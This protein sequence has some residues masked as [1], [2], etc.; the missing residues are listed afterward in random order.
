MKHI[1]KLFFLIC[2]SICLL[3]A[4]DGAID[5]AKKNLKISVLIPCHVNHVCYLYDLL[6]AYEGQTV[7]PDEAIIS[8]SEVNKTSIDTIIKIVNE[9]WKFPV[10]FFFSELCQSAGLNRNIASS[11]AVGDVFFYQDADDLPHSRSI[12]IIKYFFEHFEV[13]H[14]MYLYILPQQGIDIN[15]PHIPPLDEIEMVQSSSYDQAQSMG[16]ANGCVAVSRKVFDKVMWP[17]IH[18]A[19]DLTFNQK[20]YEHFTSCFVINVPVFIYRNYLST[21]D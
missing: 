11:Q 9:N 13:D 7:L 18:Y 17:D 12:E 21:H 8:I 6:K 1:L 19:E 2:F 3:Q 15:I 20:V 16:V 4:V 10:K 14:L 5:I